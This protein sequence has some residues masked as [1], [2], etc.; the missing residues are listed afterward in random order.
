MPEPKP[1]TFLPT[2]H[3]NGTTVG[4]SLDDARDTRTGCRQAAPLQKVL[5]NP[6]TFL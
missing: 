3:T 6:Q 4:A 5:R 1:D 2:N